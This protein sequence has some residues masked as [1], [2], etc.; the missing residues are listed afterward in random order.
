[1]LSS[2]LKCLPVEQLWHSWAD[3][4]SLVA[5]LKGTMSF[6]RHAEQ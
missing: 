1:M 2:E 6:Y 3:I 4:K 5:V